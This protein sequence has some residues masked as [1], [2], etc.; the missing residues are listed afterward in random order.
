MATKS[1]YRASQI[2]KTR[3]RTNKNRPA[4]A[5]A[6]PAAAAP[7]VYNAPSFKG[8]DARDGTGDSRPLTELGN[9]TRMFDAPGDRLRYV[10]DAGEWMRWLDAWRWDIGGADVRS[11][12]AALPSSIYYDGGRHLDEAKYFVNWARISQKKNTIKATVTL[13]DAAGVDVDALPGEVDGVDPLLQGQAPLLFDQIEKGV[14]EPE[15]DLIP[16]RSF[17]GESNS[18]NKPHKYS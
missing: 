17:H 7:V 4:L 5:P 3:R 13:L 10:H 9:A 14:V 15:G 18:G 8:T 1:N 11:L 12:A 2:K 6:K 16:I